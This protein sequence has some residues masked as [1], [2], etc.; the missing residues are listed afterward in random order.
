MFFCSSSW[1]YCYNVYNKYG[2]V[3]QAN[4]PEELPE[5]LI[6]AVRVSHIELSSAI[7]P[8]LESD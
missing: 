2:S 4:T 8:N 3:L 7:V 5:R 6:G 1:G